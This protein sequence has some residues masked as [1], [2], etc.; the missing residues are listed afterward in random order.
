MASKSRG[1]GISRGGGSRG[2]GSQYSGSNRKP[3]NHD[4]H[5]RPAIAKAGEVPDHLLGKHYRDFTSSDHWETKKFRRGRLICEGCGHWYKY[6]SKVKT[7]HFTECPRLRKRNTMREKHGLCLE[8]GSTDHE[9]TKCP[10]R[11]RLEK[12][13]EPFAYYTDAPNKYVGMSY[14]TMNERELAD[15]KFHRSIKNLCTE[16]GSGDHLH[17]A[18][19]IRLRRVRQRFNE[20]MAAVTSGMVTLNL[21]LTGTLAALPLDIFKKIL[22]FATKDL[23]KDVAFQ[24]GFLDPV[25]HMLRAGLPM[26][27]LVEAFVS[28]NTF[29]IA[30]YGQSLDSF[31]SFLQAHNAFKS[32]RA[33]SLR[34]AKRDFPRLAG[35]CAG[36][37]KLKIE[38]NVYNIG[39]WHEDPYVHGDDHYSYAEDKIPDYIQELDLPLL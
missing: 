18:C 24:P 29:H 9:W 26:E 19:E 10:I 22:F 16:C 17:Y 12:E 1:G 21:G 4:S 6:W 3:A 7:H 13:L 27:E 2:G 14:S 39:T 5:Q 30:G 38:V 36:L 25:K 11:E 8:C 31:V 35:L 32:L 37:T 28:S 23:Y 15:V 34:C 33:V 20:K